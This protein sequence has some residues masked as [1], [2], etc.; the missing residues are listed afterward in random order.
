[1][2]GLKERDI[3]YLIEA[4]KIFPEIEKVIIFGSRALG[5]YKQ[6]SDIDL[7]IVGENIS[8]TVL[9]RLIDILNNEKPIPY[10]FDIISYSDITNKE[11]KKHIDEFGKEIFN[12]YEKTKS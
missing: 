7:A 6:G 11:L 10:F 2:Y 3:N 8:N 9:L 12:K 1:M 5:N 4:F